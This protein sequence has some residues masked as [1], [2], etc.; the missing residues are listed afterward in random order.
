MTEDEKRISDEALA[1]ARANK[2]NFARALTDPKKYPGESNPVSV[3]MAGSP[4][5]G[6]TEVSKALATGLGDGF[7][8]I[9]PDEFRAELPGYNGTNSWLFQ[10][11]V[12]V[13]LGKVLD[14]V[15]DQKQS[16]LLDGTLSNLKTATENVERSLSKNRDV[17]VMYVYQEPLQAWTFVQAREAA[18]GRRI[19][20][21]RFVD[22]FFGAREVVNQLK[23]KFKQSIHVDVIFKDIDGKNRRFEANISDLNLAAPISYSREDVERIV[24]SL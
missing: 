9:D 20:P 1:W 15:F 23:V 6:K 24:R 5:A 7:L 22:Q 19:P 12:S 21:D 13:L 8:R 18:E 14:L 17:L 2:K 16:F 4:G 3:F 10:P 11:A